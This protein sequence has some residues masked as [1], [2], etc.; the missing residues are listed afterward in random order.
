MRRDRPVFDDEMR[1]RMIA[2]T[3]RGYDIQ[4]LRGAEFHRLLKLAHAEGLLDELLRDIG[5]SE[6]VPSDSSK[7]EITPEMIEA[8]RKVLL[9]WHP[10][11]DSA[12]WCVEAIFEAMDDAR[13][14]VISIRVDFTEDTELP[15][16][17][18]FSEVGFY[19]IA[20]AEKPM[21]PVN[22]KD[23]DPLPPLWL[24]KDKRWPSGWW[25]IPAMIIGCGV[26][27]VASDCED[28]AVISPHDYIVECSRCDEGYRSVVGDCVICG[29]GPAPGGNWRPYGGDPRGY[30]GKDASKEKKSLALEQLRMEHG[31]L[32]L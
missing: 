9:G 16:L 5:S 10:D 18:D 30:V 17:S 22:M 14:P 2:E 31:L 26:R 1:R 25:M 29:G 32:L 12:E 3:S 20:N 6:S 27:G 4:E 28:D 15:T 8:G 21:S 11:Y 19:R 13:A 23:R 24:P 7:V